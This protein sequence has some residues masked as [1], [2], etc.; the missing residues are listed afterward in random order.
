MDIREIN[1]LVISLPS[2]ED[3]RQAFISNNVMGYFNWIDGVVDPKP[4]R[5]IAQAH[6][7]AIRTAKENKW[8]YVLIMEDDVI[9]PGKDKTLPYID[10]AFK[11]IPN[12]W[13]ILLGGV[14]Y[15]AGEVE[16]NNYWRR[17][18]RF[19]ALH[20]YIVNESIYDKILA[21]DRN[22]HIDHWI[23][24]QCFKA[25]IPRRFWAIQADGYSDNV[26]KNTTYNSNKLANF[27]ILR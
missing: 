15:L 18:R 24:E 6:Q 5:G 19:C 21:F 14:Y 23:S 2:R 10:E 9:F 3:R 22:T 27:E 4:Y 7:N 16:V 12:D 25:Y 17:A 8:P 26:K 13:E 11:K 20:W 1:K